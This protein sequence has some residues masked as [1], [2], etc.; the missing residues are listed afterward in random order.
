MLNR[1]ELVQ[2]IIKLLEVASDTQLRIIYQIIY[3]M[4]NG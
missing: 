4:I 2:S 3:H 1:G